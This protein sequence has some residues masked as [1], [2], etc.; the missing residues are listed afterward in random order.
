M[1]S[2]W[3]S[4]E[5]RREPSRVRELTL[6]HHRPESR[7]VFVA[8][9][10][11]A[12]VPP[13]LGSQERL[14]QIVWNLLS[15]AVKFTPHHGRVEVHLETVSKYAQIRVLDTGKGIEASFIPYVF[16]DFR[17]ADST[18][19]RAYGGLGLGLAS[20]SEKR[21]NFKLNSSAIHLRQKYQADGKQDR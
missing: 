4:A 7:G 9:L 21:L 14:E 2:I 1:V 6:H 20:G 8:Q 10:V 11:D 15:N 16:D 12:T 13:V 5:G 18:T 3:G 17:Q 19:T